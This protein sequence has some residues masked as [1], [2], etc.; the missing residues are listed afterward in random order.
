MMTYFTDLYAFPGLNEL[1]HYSFIFIREML[2]Y[3]SYIS[4]MGTKT[5]SNKKKKTEEFLKKIILW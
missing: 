4:T 5:Q 1:L 3:F 2:Q